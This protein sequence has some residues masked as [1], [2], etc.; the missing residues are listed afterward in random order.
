MKTFLA[1]AFAVVSLQT[2]QEFHLCRLNTNAPDRPYQS[3]RRF[4]KTNKIETTSYSIIPCTNIQARQACFEHSN[5]FKVNLAAPRDTR[6]RAPRSLRQTF[7]GLT[8]G[9]SA[10]QRTADSPPRS[11][12]EL[13]NRNNFNIRYWSWNY[14]GCW[15]QTCPPMV[16][17]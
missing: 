3:L 8:T 7:H 1:N 15:H 17:R 12:Y 13:F 5:F 9:S 16:P 2:V 4:P 10:K 6:R 14:R 11:N